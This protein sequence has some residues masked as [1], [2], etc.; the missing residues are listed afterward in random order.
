MKNRGIKWD[1][2]SISPAVY[3]GKIDAERVATITKPKDDAS[4]K[5]ELDGICGKFTGGTTL[6]DAKAVVI[7][8]RRQ[9][10]H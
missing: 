2:Q 3:V 8:V 7:L 9:N 6:A 5:I 4:Y 1:K 10:G